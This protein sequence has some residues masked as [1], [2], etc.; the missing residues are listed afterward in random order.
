MFYKEEIKI[1]LQEPF[2]YKELY[3]SCLMG[4]VM[5]SL[6]SQATVKSKSPW[7]EL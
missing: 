7:K 2:Y 4:T 5:N 6:F 3:F 1:F